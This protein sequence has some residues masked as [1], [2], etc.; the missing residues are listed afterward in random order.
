MTV[1][2]IIPTRNR[3]AALGRTL[4]S[5]AQVDFRP[6]EV[7]VLVVDNG[8]VDKTRATFELIRTR[9]SGVQYQY[10]Y[11]PMP[12]LLSGRHC[13]ALEAGGDICVF[14]DDDVRL[15]RGWLTAIE[16]SFLDPQ[17]AL[18]GGPSR[19]L[20]QSPPPDWLEDFVCDDEHGRHCADL[21]LMDG[22]EQIR[23][24]DPCY[25][26]GLNFAIRRRVLLDLGGFHPDYVPKCL[27][28]FQG[29]GETGLSLKVGRAG[30]KALYHPRAAVQHEVPT[31]RMTVEYFQ[32]R[33]YYQ[34]VCNSYTKIRAD[35]ELA[36]SGRSWKGP[37]RRVKHLFVEAARGVR[38]NK[39]QRQVAKAYMAGYGFHQEEVRRDP[40][41]LEWVLRKDYWDYRLPEGWGK[42]YTHG[43]AS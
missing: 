15:D 12:G 27:Q 6:G 9:I 31:S 2:I 16:E 23:E 3:D 41:L 25:V 17:V 43:V 18:V 36:Q 7:E 20:F 42:Y 30:L 37:L 38:L 40:K 8:S 13:G 14:L 28:R 22:G 32:E 19:P 35:G 29:D 39:I 33:A 21:S 11:E 4:A 24:I 1:S 5:L 10:L 34:G 26:W